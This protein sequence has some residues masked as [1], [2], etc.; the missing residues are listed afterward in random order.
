MRSETIF[1]GKY[2]TDYTFPNLFQ[3]EEVNPRDLPFVT[4]PYCIA[5]FFLIRLA[6]VESSITSLRSSIT[7]SSFLYPSS[8]I[9][10]ENWKFFLSYHLQWYHLSQKC[11]CMLPSI[12]WPTWRQVTMTFDNVKLRMMKVSRMM[13]L[14]QYGWWFGETKLLTKK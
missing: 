13:I 10:L 12:W 2:E 4:P 7:I 14:Q 9:D 8:K 6:A 11:L 1:L 5:S 3:W